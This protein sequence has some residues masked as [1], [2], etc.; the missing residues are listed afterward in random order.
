[1]DLGDEF[2][3]NDLLTQIETAAAPKS[4]VTAV[5]GSS[6]RTQ[7]VSALLVDARK[8]AAA[9]QQHGLLPD[10]R[11]ILLGEPG[12]AVLVALLAVW[13]SGASAIVLPSPWRR[14]RSS[15]WRDRLLAVGRLLRAKLVLCDERDAAQVSFQEEICTVG[16]RELADS[17]HYRFNEPDRDGHR[18][19]IIQLTSGTTEQPRAVPLSH[20]RL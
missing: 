4:T 13:Y 20:A 16:F 15:A 2:E 18:L 7:D 6:T 14:N 5:N 3:G 12:I 1:M 9:L 19:A 17:P 8:R 10:D 11:V